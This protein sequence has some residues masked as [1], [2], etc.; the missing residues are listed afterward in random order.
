MTLLLLE[1]DA[2][3]IYEELQDADTEDLEEEYREDRMDQMISRYGYQEVKK[4]TENQE[5]E[6][7]NLDENE[8]MEYF[9]KYLGIDCEDYKCFSLDRDIDFDDWSH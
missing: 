7:I 3:A 5:Q 4:M 1:K 2:D 6:L 9:A 8:D